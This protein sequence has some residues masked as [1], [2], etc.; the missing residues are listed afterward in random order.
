MNIQNYRFKSRNAASDAV[1]KIIKGQPFYLLYLYLYSEIKKGYTVS[2]LLIGGDF[3]KLCIVNSG[4][5]TK[6]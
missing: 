5:V 3:M 6:K 2:K 4:I 1:F